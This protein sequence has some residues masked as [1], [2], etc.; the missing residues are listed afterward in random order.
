MLI[1]SA[2]MIKVAGVGRH[3]DALATV[4]PEKLI[5]Y[6]KSLVVVEFLN[7]AAFTCA[8]IAILALYLRI[9]TLKPYRISAY[10]IGSIVLANWLVAFVL[11]CFKCAPFAYN[12]DRT[13][14]YG[15]CLDINREYQW[16]TFPNIVTDVMILLL[17]MR[18]VWK[19]Q[20]PRVQKIGLAVTFLTGCL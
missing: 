4:D 18:V 1:E 19:L 14:P 15:S 2:V 8:K 7:V 10:V 13:I 20:V 5:N 6:R 11:S 12:W 3:G 17:P 16:I 9:F